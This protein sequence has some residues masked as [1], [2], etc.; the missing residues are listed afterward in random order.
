MV[1]DCAHVLLM[2]SDLVDE[3]LSEELLDEMRE[4][5]ETCEC[6]RA[7]LHTFTRTLDLCHCMG[8][9]RLPAA[10]RREYHHWLHVEV[11]HT[12]VRHGRTVRV[13]KSV[14]V[15]K[16]SLPRHA[17]TV[18]ALPAPDKH[19]LEGEIVEQPVRDTHPPAQNRRPHR[20]G[21]RVKHRRNKTQ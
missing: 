15:P 5:V 19:V 13:C 17:S 12:E 9:V 8:T 4:H 11:C 14:T 3:M 6:C 16:G 2:M 10:R 20:R 21:V 18:R 1:L 7:M